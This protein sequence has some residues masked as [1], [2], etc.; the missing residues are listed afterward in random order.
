MSKLQKVDPINVKTA[1]Q[2]WTE[3]GAGKTQSI[4]DHVTEIVKRPN[5]PQGEAQ[6]PKQRQ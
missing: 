1:K 3:N 5:I 4:K 6:A 2:F